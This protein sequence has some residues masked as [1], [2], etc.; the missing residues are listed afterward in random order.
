MWAQLFPRSSTMKDDL[1]PD[2]RLNVD[3]GW[4]VQDHLLCTVRSLSFK[5]WL[6]LSSFLPHN[7]MLMDYNYSCVWLYIHPF[8]TIRCSITTAKHITMQW[9]MRNSYSSWCWKWWWNSNVVTPNRD[10]KFTPIRK[11]FVTLDTP[12]LWYKMIHTVYEIWTEVQSILGDPN[13]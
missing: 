3:R 7:S 2:S 6:N 1:V 10:S 12:W 4:D 11:K 13:Q 9:C 8:I 5:I